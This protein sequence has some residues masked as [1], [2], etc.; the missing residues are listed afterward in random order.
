MGRAA[1]NRIDGSAF[2]IKR[3]SN[4]TTD[5]SGC[6]ESPCRIATQKKSRGLSLHTHGAGATT[7]TNTL[8]A[9]CGKTPINIKQ[10]WFPSGQDSVYFLSRWILAQLCH[11]RSGEPPLI[12]RG[13]KHTK[14]T[15]EE[16]KT[17][18]QIIHHSNSPAFPQSGQVRQAGQVRSHQG[19]FN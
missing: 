13:I 6:T 15:K 9:T 11:A 10:I 7:F 1:A 12:R 14:N 18:P 17:V 19:W 8:S 2:T 3:K 4:W 16:K 5:C